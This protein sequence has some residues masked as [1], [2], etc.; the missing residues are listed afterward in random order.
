MRSL[1]LEV[2]FDK[3]ADGG[4][5]I[6]APCMGDIRRHLDAVITA[7]SKELRD[8]KTF[9]KAYRDYQRLVDRMI[10]SAKKKKYTELHEDTLMDARSQCGLIFFCDP[11]LAP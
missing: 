7:H 6:S 5:G 4:F 9:S 1:F 11:K 8:P 2:L 10:K 3:A